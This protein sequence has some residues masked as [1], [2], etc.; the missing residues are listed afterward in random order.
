[1]KALLQH[2]RAKLSK[3]CTPTCFILLQGTQHFCCIESGSSL[4]WSEFV[5]V[6]LASSEEPS[7]P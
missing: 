3:V 4:A 7:A 2:Q 1:M 5:K 6:G